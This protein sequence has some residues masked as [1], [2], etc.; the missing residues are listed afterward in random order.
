[1]SLLKSACKGQKGKETRINLRDPCLF[2]SFFN[3][4]VYDNKSVMSDKVDRNMKVIGSGFGRTGTLSMKV[5][6]EQ[7]GFDPCYHMETVLTRPSHLNFWHDV[8]SG[9]AVDWHQIFDDFQAAVDFPA[10][11][12]YKELMAVY[13]E[14]KVI[15]TIRDPERWYDSTYETIYKMKDVFPQWMRQYVPWVRR[16]VEMGDGMFWDRLFAG[17]FENCPRMIQ[18]FNDYTEDVKRTV[19]ADRLLVFNVKEGWRPLCQFL[20]VT[21][22]DTPFPH[23]NDRALMLRRFQAIRLLTR[24]VPTAFAGLIFLLLYRLIRTPSER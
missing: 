15:H 11:S 9:K 23:K 5:A 20:D 17:Q 14:A 6:L 2:A 8:A 1:M 4:C 16:F 22:P 10:S 12:V 3:A 13:P 24:V 7:L 19:P 21:V 18:V